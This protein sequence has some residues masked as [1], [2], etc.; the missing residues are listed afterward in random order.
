MSMDIVIIDRINQ[1]KFWLDLQIA[2]VQHVAYHCE[3]VKSR[4]NF[5]VLNC[6]SSKLQ[7]EEM[8]HRRLQ[9][10][11]S[12]LVL[13]SFTIVLSIFCLIQYVSK[14]KALFS[15]Q[16]H[17][18]EGFSSR[19]QLHNYQYYYTTVFYKHKRIAVF[20]LNNYFPG[21]YIF[22]NQVPA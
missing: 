4:H 16:Q 18:D 10:S 7:C 12:T 8:C 19:L 17:D 5:V 9:F 21:R 3:S 22:A 20:Q 14:R 1:K 15:L 6:A 13:Y 11:F 2:I